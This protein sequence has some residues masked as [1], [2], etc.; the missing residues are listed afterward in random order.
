LLE[1][2][3]VLF[4]GGAPVTDPNSYVPA[5]VVAA[6]YDPNGGAHAIGSMDTARDGQTATLLPDGSVLIAGGTADGGNALSS[7][8]LFK[9]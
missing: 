7:A 5:A 6:L 4:A 3:N 9:Q 2:G 8:E 1:N